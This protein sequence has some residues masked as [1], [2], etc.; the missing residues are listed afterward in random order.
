[1]DAS[2]LDEIALVANVEGRLEVWRLTDGGGVARI[3]ENAT[4]GRPWVNVAMGRWREGDARDFLG[5]VREADSPFVSFVVYRFNTE[6]QE[7]QD[8][9]AE[10][11]SPSPGVIFFGNI[12]AEGDEEAIMLRDALE[13]DTARVRLITRSRDGENMTSVIEDNLGGLNGYGAGATGDIDGDGKNE[14]VIARSD[15]LRIFASPE[16]SNVGTD[17]A[18]STDARNLAIGDLDR[19]GYVEELL[20]VPAPSTVAATVRSGEVGSSTTVT[21]TGSTP[22]GATGKSIAFAW[23]VSGSPQWA[24][25]SANRSVTPAT[26]TVQFD[27]SR[28]PPGTYTA[29]LNLTS[30]DPLVL[31]QPVAVPLRLTVSNGMFLNPASLEFIKVPCTAP[32]AAQ[33]A[34]LR[35][36]APAGTI[37]TASLLEAAPGDAQAAGGTPS[38]VDVGWPSSVPWASASSPNG[39]A[40]ENITVVAD[41]AKRTAD[42]QFARLVVIARVDGVDIVRTAPI[43]LMCTNQ[44][45]W[46]PVVDSR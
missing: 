4:A 15:R 6:E 31:T 7:V 16:A 38:A 39:V 37:Y 46:L 17:E 9:R 33:S 40:V 27:A 29:D 22:S 13:T 43:T 42:L 45:T 23:S 28:L 30:S 3:A 41:F 20:L 19:N 24:K 34:A 11:F 44:R 10:A 1:M 25:V 21:V 12:N 14:I 2:G 5:A 18:R 26:L 8:D 36:E 32:F 35:V